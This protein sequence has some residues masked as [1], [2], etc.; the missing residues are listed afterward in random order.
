MTPANAPLRRF[1]ALM[2]RHGLDASAC[3]AL[4]YPADLIEVVVVSDA[5]SDGTDG[6]VRAFDDPR[7]TVV[8][9]D[10]MIWIERVPAKFDVAMPP[11]IAVV[12]LA[13]IVESSRVSAV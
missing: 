7:V 8:N 13:V 2:Q 6:I 12:A 9:E 10:A 11:P 4:D 1:D 3:L 5:S